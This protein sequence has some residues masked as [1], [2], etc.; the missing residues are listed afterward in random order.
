VN[1]TRLLELIGDEP[2][3]NSAVL[4]A[5]PVN[6][7]DLRRQ[8]SRWTKAGCRTAVLCE[9]LRGALTWAESPP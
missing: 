4:L 1:F 5:G 2:V 9:L 6:P 7:A 3:F 8:L